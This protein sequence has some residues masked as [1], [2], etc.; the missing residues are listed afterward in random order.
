[1]YSIKSIKNRKKDI[2]DVFIETPNVYFVGVNKEG[3]SVVSVK[4]TLKDIKRGGYL[5]I[6]KSHS[7]NLRTSLITK[8]LKKGDSLMVIYTENYAFELR[9]L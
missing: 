7:D 3:K 2:K 5:I 4:P 6:F 1:M 8:T 9:T